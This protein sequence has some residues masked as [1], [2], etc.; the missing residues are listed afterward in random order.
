MG[1]PNETKVLIIDDDA[2][3]LDW[4]SDVLTDQNYIVLTADSAALAE[5]ICNN[6]TVDLVITDIIMPDKDGIEVILWFK[7]NYESVPILAI[8]G[9][10][11]INGAQYL[12][13]AKKLGADKVMTKP[14][15]AEELITV[16]AELLES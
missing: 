4:I 9:D 6:E 12:K 11:V 10:G 16:V 8:S 1:K 5:E 14:I 15:V 7:K 13:S 2:F 3:Q